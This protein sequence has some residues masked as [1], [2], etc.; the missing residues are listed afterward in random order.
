[1]AIPDALYRVP[2]SESEVYLTFDDGPYSPGAGD[3]QN[4]S[5]LLAV[6]D[7]MRVKYDPSLAATFFIN[8]WALV[9]E[10][11]PIVGKPV[12]RWD[13]YGPK[14]TVRRGV[15]R[16]ILDRGHD[17]A[18]H[19]QH[20]RNPWGYVQKGLGLPTIAEMLVEIGLTSRALSY[21]DPHPAD[22]PTIAPGAIQRYFRAP[23]DP[24]YWPISAPE[25]ATLR[26]PAKPAMSSDVPGNIS[27]RIWFQKCLAAA[28]FARYK[29]I[30]FNIFAR[31]DG[32]KGPVTPRDV[33]LNCIVGKTG[34]KGNNDKL[35]FNRLDSA[36]RKGAVILMHNGRDWTNKALPDVVRY[37]YEHGY[38]IRKLPDNL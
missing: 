5:E 7:A 14:A 16:K 38:V 8:G 22:S 2:T 29:Y 32:A 21:V 9:N 25:K 12:Q 15:A 10:T 3:S 37:I 4:T 11:T 17:L 28:A 26:I 31:D 23:G 27:K 1:M 20:H 33:Y 24:S 35:S 6:L 36:D 19:S 30:S 13:P 34:D 18:N